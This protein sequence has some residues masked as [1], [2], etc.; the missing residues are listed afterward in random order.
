[1][2]SRTV[3]HS[4]HLKNSHITFSNAFHFPFTSSA[5]RAFLFFS[6][7]L[8]HII[9]FNVSRGFILRWLL[10]SVFLVCVFRAFWRATSKIIIIWQCSPIVRFS[11]SDSAKRKTKK[12]NASKSSSDRV[13][14]RET[15]DRKYAQQIYYL[16]FPAQRDQYSPQVIQTKNPE[17][18]TK[19][20]RIWIYFVFS[21]EISSIWVERRWTAL[22]AVCVCAVFVF[23][24]RAHLCLDVRLKLSSAHSQTNETRR[25]SDEWRRIE[26][27]ASAVKSIR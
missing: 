17:E 23:W 15:D 19:C 26:S 5:L 16:K 18:I 10:F 2:P 14:E 8:L 21:R 24:R 27:N 22:C 12:K 11:W 9:K 4:K 7:F 13:S 25:K 20:S 6:L 3:P 1:M